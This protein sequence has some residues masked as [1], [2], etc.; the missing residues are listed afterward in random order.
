MVQ[1]FIIL[2]IFKFQEKKKTRL[3]SDFGFFLRLFFLIDLHFRSDL[4]NSESHT[5]NLTHE[6]AMR[7]EILNQDNNLSLLQ[8]L[9][10]V[11][12][13]SDDPALFLNPRFA[14]YRK[15]PFLLNDMNK[16]VERII[17][18]LKKQEKIMI[19]ADY[20]VDGVT[21]SYCIYTFITKFL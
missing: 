21:S 11:R 4:L 6:M 17:D 16:G 1:K 8:R 2:R 20:D 14:N 18:A 19:F 9:L 12:Q 10:A 3:K 5:I 15:D 7:Y 13:V